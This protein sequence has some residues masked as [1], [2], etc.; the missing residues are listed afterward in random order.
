MLEEQKID[1]LVVV[2]IVI[3]VVAKHKAVV[4]LP[5]KETHSRSTSFGSGYRH[6]APEKGSLLCRR[7]G[8]RRQDAWCWERTMVVVAT[9]EEVTIISIIWCTHNSRFFSNIW[10]TR[11]ELILNTKLLCFDS[12]TN[13]KSV[14][15]CPEMFR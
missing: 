2:A 3:V 4:I 8:V 9:R 1:V 12:D 6:E 10:R 14:C 5:M 7:S 11:K 15:L 13:T